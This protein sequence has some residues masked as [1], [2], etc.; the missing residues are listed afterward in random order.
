MALY[1]LGIVFFCFFYTAVVF[2]LEETA[3]NPKR[4]GRFIPVIRPGKNTDNSLDY[5]LTPLSTF[6]ASHTA[7]I[8]LVLELAFDRFGLPFHFCRSRQPVR[9]PFREQLSS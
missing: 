1:G 5:V 6:G 2:N 4:N 8:C 9:P 3:D 7:F